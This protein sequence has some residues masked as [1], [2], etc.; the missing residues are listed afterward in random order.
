MTGRLAIIAA[1]L[2]AELRRARCRTADHTKEPCKRCD[3]LAA[4]DAYVSIVQLPAVGRAIEL[5]SRP[6]HATDGPAIP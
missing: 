1:D 4:F 3:A 6:T 5:S 2:A